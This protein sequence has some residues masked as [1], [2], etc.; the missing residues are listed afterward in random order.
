[1][2]G[3]PARRRTIV[4]SPEQGRRERRWEARIARRG[5]RALRCGGGVGRGVRRGCARFAE[6]IER[7]RRRLA[8]LV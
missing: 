1:M 2:C 8:A 4:R 3:P 5:F 7:V 6:V